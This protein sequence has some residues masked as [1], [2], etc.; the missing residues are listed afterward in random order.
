V[1]S[2]PLRSRIFDLLQ[3]VYVIIERSPKR[4]A[5]YS[6]C[7]SSLGLADGLKSLQSLSATRWSARCVNLRIVHRCL[8][9]VINFLESRNVVESL[10]LLSALYLFLA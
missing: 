4:H 5:Q 9:A 8:P 7:I 2:V 3:K 10:G 6:A 1:N